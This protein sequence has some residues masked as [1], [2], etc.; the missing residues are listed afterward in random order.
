MKWVINTVLF[1][2]LILSIGIT[3][4]YSTENT[5]EYMHVPF[6][7]INGLIVVEAT[8]NDEK[9][10][11][12]FDTGANDIILNG[13]ELYNT[14]VFDTPT[15][16]TTAATKSIKKITVGAYTKENL[17]AFV[18][19]LSSIESYLQIQLD[20]II[21]SE[22]FVPNNIMVDFEVQVITLSALPFSNAESIASQKFNFEIHEELIILQCEL[23]K[24]DLKFVL[25][26][27][28]SL[29]TID[30]S[31]YNRF[32]AGKKGTKEQLVDLYTASDKKET[33][34]KAALDNIKI[35]DYDLNQ[36]TFMIND[37]SDINENLSVKVDGILNLQS[38]KADKIIIN[39]PDRTLFIN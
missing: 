37:L 16:S 36:V 28:S 33:V 13:K 34:R 18:I 11:Y 22:F 30:L 20:G 29:S 23:G 35:G 38:L 15:G 9:G 24:K 10:N 32:F 3:E 27:G 2:L 7:E 5:A 1:V 19:D 14:E 39:M 4:L 31:V 6:T 21:G 25:D 8:I 17:D 26:S 12:I